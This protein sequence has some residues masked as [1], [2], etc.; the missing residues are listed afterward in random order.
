MEVTTLPQNPAAA[1]DAPA[2]NGT[3]LAD[4]LL[5]EIHDLD[6]AEQKALTAILRR[7]KRDREV[8]GP[9]EELSFVV[10]DLKSAPESDDFMVWITLNSKR[11]PALQKSFP[12]AECIPLSRDIIDITATLPDVIDARTSR[13]DYSGGPLSLE[14]LSTLLYRGYGVRGA[15][16]AYNLPDVPLRVV[17]TAGGLQSVDVY[18]AVNAVETLEQGL[19]HYDA[20]GHALEKL[21]TGIMRWRISECC[22]RHEWLAYAGVVLILVP[23]LPRLYWKY[24]RR[25]YRMIHIDSGIVNQNLHLVATSLNLPSCMVMGF[26]DDDLND[27]LNLDGRDEFATIMLA[28]GRYTWEP[29]PKREVDASGNGHQH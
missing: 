16:T 7:A 13:R 11:G 1:A 20:I 10:N 9:L 4:D 25:A 22:A 5:D 18:L 26:Q 3:A 2:P 6:P 17:P 19:Y 23:N 12:D 27:V 24:G 28:V 21:D 29:G 8:N 15:I 14:E